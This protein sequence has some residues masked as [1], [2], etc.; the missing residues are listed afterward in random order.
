MDLMT[1][2]V[3]ERLLTMQVG[4]SATDAASARAALQCHR[5]QFPPAA[6]QQASDGLERA[7]D[8]RIRLQPWFGAPGGADLFTSGATP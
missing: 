8:G 6:L 3:D 5:S 4:F 1:Y 7:W 2:P